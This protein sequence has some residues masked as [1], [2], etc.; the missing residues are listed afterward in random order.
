MKPSRSEVGGIQR[1]Q[2]Q[3]NDRFVVCSGE[4]SEST[5]LRSSCRRSLTA[6]EE[7]HVYLRARTV[8]TRQKGTTS[9]AS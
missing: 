6:K 2:L 3:R 8:R 4:L 1:D 9:K 5:A 7:R